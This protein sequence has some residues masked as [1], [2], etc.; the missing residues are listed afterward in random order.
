MTR[1][2]R[3]TCTRALYARLEA[4]DN[5][6]RDNADYYAKGDWR[7]ELHRKRAAVEILEIRAALRELRFIEW[8][9]RAA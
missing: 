2:T 8:G 7:T 4:L 9:T 6:L 1:S 5:D 3:A